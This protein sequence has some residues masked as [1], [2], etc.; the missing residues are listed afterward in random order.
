MTNNTVTV[1]VNLDNMTGAFELLNVT[2]ELALAG[3]IRDGYTN[4]YLRDG[5]VYL[6][7]IRTADYP[8]IHPMTE[9]EWQALDAQA[10]TE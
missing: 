3:L 7:P 1:I 10:R 2:P 6:P 4:A 9:E 5:Y 8:N